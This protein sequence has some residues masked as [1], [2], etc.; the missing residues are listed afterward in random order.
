MSILRFVV[1][2][3]GSLFKSKRQLESENLALKPQVALPRD[4]GLYHRYT[5]IAA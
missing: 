3:L 1:T 2:F 4:G 5:R